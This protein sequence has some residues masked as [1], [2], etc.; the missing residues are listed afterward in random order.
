MLRNSAVLRL[1]CDF[2]NLLQANV[3]FLNPPLKNQKTRGSLFSGG[4]EKGKIGLGW[5]EIFPQ[6]AITRSKLTIET[7]KGCIGVVR[8]LYC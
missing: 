2:T 5:V 7:Q 3:S 4:V 6:S 1:L 8:C